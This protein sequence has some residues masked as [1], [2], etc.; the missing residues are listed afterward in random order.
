[1]PDNLSFQGENAEINSS[2]TLL[3]LNFFKPFVGLFLSKSWLNVLRRD[4]PG[5]YLR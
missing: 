3:T 4:I 1:M 2:L 5:D